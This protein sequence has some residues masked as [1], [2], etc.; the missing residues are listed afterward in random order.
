MKLGLEQ[1]TNTKFDNARIEI[2]VKCIMYEFCIPMGNF[3]PSMIPHLPVSVT[4]YHVL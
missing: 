1:I 3:S 4:T 2:G